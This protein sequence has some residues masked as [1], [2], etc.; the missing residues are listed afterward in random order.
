MTSITI[1]SGNHRMQVKGSHSVS[2]F[3]LEIMLM[4]KRNT[5]K[6]AIGHTWGYRHLAWEGEVGQEEPGCGVFMLSA[7][8]S[9]FDWLPYLDYIHRNKED[10]R[11]RCWYLSLILLLSPLLCFFIGEPHLIGTVASLGLSFITFGHFLL[12]SPFNTIS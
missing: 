2:S 10:K 7:W 12:C 6:G 4:I 1:V 5:N 3:I 8:V 9:S 11:E